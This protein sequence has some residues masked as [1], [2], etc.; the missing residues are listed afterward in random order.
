MYDATKVASRSKLSIALNITL[1]VIAT[2]AITITAFASNEVVNNRERIAAI[3]ADRLTQADG[4]EV[5]DAISEI[6]R[7]PPQEWLVARIDRIEEKL[8]QLLKNRR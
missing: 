5:W 7:Q 4:K 1:S 6:R 8:D 2:G 3:E